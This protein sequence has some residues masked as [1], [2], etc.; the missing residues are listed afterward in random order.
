MLCGVAAQWLRLKKAQLQAARA[1]TTVRHFPHHEL[2][3]QAD[4]PTLAWR[5]RCH[6]LL[7]LW[8]LVKGMGPP[9]LTTLLPKFVVDRCARNLRSPHSLE[10]PPS[11]SARFL[12]SFFAVAIPEW[13]SLP[14]SCPTSS[15]PASSLT[16]IS[17]FFKA[18][19]FTFGL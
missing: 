14:L 1:I 11:N 10:F 5:R 19:R 7:L 8:K 6:R 16:S 18:D 13:N 15:S 17:R 2:L 3:C 9:H 4:L 12:T